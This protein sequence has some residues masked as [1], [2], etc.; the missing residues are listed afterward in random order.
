MDIMDIMYI[1]VVM[2]MMDIMDIMN[3]TDIMNIMIITDWL[4]MAGAISAL[5]IHGALW[6]AILNEWWN[7]EYIHRPFLPRWCKW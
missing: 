1:I 3:I 4:A 6:I 2:D 5:V 7:I